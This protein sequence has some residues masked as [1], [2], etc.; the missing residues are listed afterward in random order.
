MSNAKLEIPP[1]FN[2]A[3]KEQ[4]IA[5]V[6]DLWNQIAQESGNVP[7]PESHKR[8]LRE[9]LEAFRS[10][11]H[12]GRPWNEVRDQLLEKIRNT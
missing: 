9:R 7:V 8:V 6:Q 4:K 11:P 2:S 1:E 10:N 12:T 3:P 5:F